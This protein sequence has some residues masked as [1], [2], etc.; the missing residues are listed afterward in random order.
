MVVNTVIIVELWHFH[1]SLV[2]KV[3]LGFEFIKWLGMWLPAIAAPEIAGC[4]SCR[5]DAGCGVR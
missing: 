5:E 2:G 4:L 1:V 3:C